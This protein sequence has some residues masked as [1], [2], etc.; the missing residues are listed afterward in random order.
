[1]SNPLNLQTAI[2][3][4]QIVMED[5]VIKICKS[6]GATPEEWELLTG[7]KPW[8]A[9]ERHIV[10][11]LLDN[12]V[13]GMM[14]AIGLP[15]IDIHAEYCAAVIYSFIGNSNT[16]YGCNL[17]A[18][19]HSADQLGN[20]DGSINTLEGCE[21]ITAQQLFALVCQMKSNST[22]DAIARRFKDKTD[23]Q[24]SQTLLNGVNDEKKQSKK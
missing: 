9:E 7:T 20:I 12:L 18:N 11:R 22:C 14:D 16:F 2:G 8:K 10:K 3:S 13:H 15:H 5:S 24:M 21:K 6:L 4:M 23:I 17:L 1:M 19:C